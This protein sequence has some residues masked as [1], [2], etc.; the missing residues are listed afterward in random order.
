MAL[1]VLE[2][3]KRFGEVD[4]VAGLDLEL[5]AGEVFG[6]LG[7]NGAGKTTTISMVATWLRPT[8]GDAVV[9]GRSARHEATA[10]RGLIGVVAQEVALYPGLTAA[11]N[12]R[13]F[14]R[15]YAVPAVRL[16]RRIDRL[17]LDVGLEPRRHDRVSTFSGGMKRRLNLAVALVHEPRLVLLDEPTVGVDPQSRENIF[18]MVRR[19]REEGTAVLYTTHYMEEAE[20]LCD[21]IGIMDAGR[22][23][24][25]GA[26]PHLLARAACHDVVVLRGLPAAVDRRAI[27][28]LPGVSRLD[29]RDGAIRLFVANAAL[30]LGGLSRVIGR[31]AADVAVEIAPPSLEHLFLQ[32]TGHELRD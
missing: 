21:R 30:V 19:L 10:V 13:F 12:L 23:I 17:L 28:G 5:R 22:M 1:R 7:P 26:L 14:G 24:A 2:F 4:A 27:G 18:S 6:L 29:E 16:E 3:R 9:F 32:L 8:A 11:E 15:M 25:S 31:F 20:R